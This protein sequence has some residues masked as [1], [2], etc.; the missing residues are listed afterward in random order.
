M[1][2]GV[3]LRRTLQKYETW[4]KIDEKTSVAF[5]RFFTNISDGV[6]VK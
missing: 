6:I 5:I 1:K 2:L 3:E 4:A